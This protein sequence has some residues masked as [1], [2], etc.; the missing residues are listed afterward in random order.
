MYNLVIEGNESFKEA[1][2]KGSTMNTA[3]EI[4]G[5]ISVTSHYSLGGCFFLETQ[6][7]DYDEYTRIPSAVSFDGRQYGKTGW[8]SDRGVAYLKTGR[9]FAT[10]I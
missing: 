9:P 1:K 5:I 7:H 4:K 6:C 3:T 8:N 10:C 2:R